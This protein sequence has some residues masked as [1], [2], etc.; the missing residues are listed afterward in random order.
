[1]IAPSRLRAARAPASRRAADRPDLCATAV[2]T[3]GR[4]MSRDFPLP[5]EPPT[6][7]V[8]PRHAMSQTDADNPKGMSYSWGVVTVVMTLIGWSSV[9]LFL[10]HFAASIDAWTSN[11]WRYSVAA[12]LWAPALVVA[13]RRKGGAGNLWR[14]AIVPSCLNAAGQVCFTWAHYLIEP[15]LLTFALRF[16][17]VFVA[18]GAFLLFPGERAIV[19]SRLYLTGFVLVLVGG[20]AA[21]VRGS[22]ACPGV[23]LQGP[24]LAVLSGALFA[25]YGLSVRGCM[26]G[27]HPI[28]AFAAISLYTS[29]AMLALMVLLGER[30]GMAALDLSRQQFALLALSA[31]V[32]IALGHVFYYISIARLGV[33]VSTGVIQLQPFVVAAGSYVLFREALNTAQWV[34]GTAAVAGALLMLETQR[35]SHRAAKRAERTRLAAEARKDELEAVTSVGAGTIDV[36]GST[37]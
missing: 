26:A 24:G 17:I 10:H 37:R 1:M 12:L 31:V 30:S 33:A 7:C 19:R 13:V 22:W 32:G 28:T 35:R 20:F 36:Q 2:S 27:I 29:G 25:A 15:G 11:G 21:G 9:P 34:S 18:L 16:Q 23:G 3:G 5:P 4:W 6:L 8:A 14:A